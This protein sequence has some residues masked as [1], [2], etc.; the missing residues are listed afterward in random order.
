MDR[1]KLLFG[2][3]PRA[4]MCTDPQWPKRTAYEPQA[5]PALMAAESTKRGTRP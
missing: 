1:G 5:W 2:L 3:F 4:G